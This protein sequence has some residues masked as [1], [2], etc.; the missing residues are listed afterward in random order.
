MTDKYIPPAIV[1]EIL[2]NVYTDFNKLSAKLTSNEETMKEL[3][4]KFTIT[5]IKKYK[6]LQTENIALSAAL[7]KETATVGK[8]LYAFSKSSQI[9][10]NYASS[11]VIGKL[12]DKKLA[13]D[14]IDTNFYNK[15]TKNLEWLKKTLSTTPFVD[16]QLSSPE[17]NIIIKNIENNTYLFYN[18]KLIIKAKYLISDESF[19]FNKLLNPNNKKTLITDNNKKTPAF[20]IKFIDVLMTLKHVDCDKRPENHNHP[21]NLWNKELNKVS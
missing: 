17:S 4:N 20:V 1:T 6:K 2:K 14:K 13:Y 3:L 19:D 10:K 18:E 16:F 9:Y 11:Y 12:P 15:F 7:E 8:T 5:S 21:I